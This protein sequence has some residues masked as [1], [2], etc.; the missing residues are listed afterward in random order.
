M[1]RLEQCGACSVTVAPGSRTRRSAHALLRGQFA[2]RRIVSKSTAPTGPAPWPARPRCRVLSRPRGFA[3]RATRWEGC[4][5][6][7]APMGLAQPLDRTKRWVR[8]ASPR[9]SRAEWTSKGSMTK[10]T[11]A[12]HSTAAN[13]RA[14]LNK[15]TLGCC[16]EAEV[17]AGLGSGREAFGA[18]T[19]A[20]PPASSQRTRGLISGT[21]W[22]LKVAP[23]QQ[24]LTRRNGRRR[25]RMRRGRARGQRSTWGG[26][27]Q[28]MA[29]TR[30]G[31]P[32][33]ATRGVYA[34]FWASNAQLIS[35][36]SY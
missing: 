5:R 18:P 35:A 27:R 2:Q 28:A 20:R 22:G 11:D 33:N 24:L 32:E 16:V 7:P 23:F 9:P 4:G 36:S 31:R 3:H 14:V 26:K 1:L 30:K 34:I 21:S 29:V 8:H 19:P 10:A 6:L 17:E 13:A 12:I 15:G 25:G